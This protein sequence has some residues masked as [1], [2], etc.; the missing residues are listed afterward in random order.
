M[1]NL[2]RNRCNIGSND[3]YIV[4]NVETVADLSHL[5]YFN[6]HNIISNL[7]GRYC[8]NARQLYYCSIQHIN[9]FLSFN[10]QK[11][12]SIY[13][14]QAINSFK[15]QSQ[16]GILLDL[17]HP[18][19]VAVNAF[20]KMSKGKQNQSII[21]FGESGSGKSETAKYVIKY[22]L[23]AVPE[24]KS[25][26]H[27][28]SI[29]LADELI[30][31]SV[32][33]ESSSII[34]TD[35]DDE[36]IYQ[37]AVTETEKYIA[38]NSKDIYVSTT[39]QQ[40][41]MLSTTILE[42]FGNAKTM[43]NN[44]SSRFI[45]YVQL[46]YSIPQNSQENINIVGL[47][48]KTYLFEKLRTTH[49]AQNEQNF[50]IFY[51]LCHAFKSNKNLYLQSSD[52]FSYLNKEITV[53]SITKQHDVKFKELVTALKVFGI[54][55]K[56]QFNLW[57]IISGIINLG[58]IN[59][60]KTGDGLCSIHPDSMEYIEA[61]SS[62]WGISTQQIES[63]LTTQSLYIFRKKIV[64]KFYYDATIPN[65][66][67]IATDIYSKVFSWICKR[68]NSAI[69]FIDYDNNCYYIGILDVMGFQNFFHN[70]LYHLCVNHMNE[71]LQQYINESI[72]QKTQIKFWKSEFEE[73]DK[74][75]FE[76][77]ENEDK[78]IFHLL[79]TRN[80]IHKLNCSLFSTDV[81]MRNTNNSVICRRKEAG[82]G[83][84]MGVKPG[85][86]PMCKTKKING[87]MIN[88]F[89][90]EI[91]YDVGEEFLSKNVEKINNDTLDMMRK[92][93]NGLMQLLVKDTRKRS[94][95]TLMTSIFNSKLKKLM[96]NLQSTDSYFILCM[97]TNHQK[98][99]S[100]W[101]DEIVK[102]Q[103]LGYG[104]LDSMKSLRYK[105][106]FMSKYIRQINGEM[107]I[108]HEVVHL[109]LLYCF[110]I[111]VGNV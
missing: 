17:S 79:Q 90:D 91:T 38:S 100:V 93:T 7:K 70:S 34:S 9:V 97:N 26:L 46:F 43:R 54:G 77:I 86:W 32:S 15:L 63:R 66:D 5:L 48:L 19:A 95:Y 74:K 28:S 53:N 14:T 85:N 105:D 99:H 61:L 12:L 109:I 94:R 58:N 73:Q 76:L 69:S 13:D 84:I 20:I 104:I 27:E 111:C 65:R 35:T 30:D 108:P 81:L 49:Q 106:L 57:M 67:T 92:S 101:N 41:I 98:S 40:Q 29:D 2:T 42:A 64:K 78:G 72:T 6:A 25:T 68:I 87:I 4:E 96:M 71:K 55:N 50:H 3:T 11:P 31:S 102:Q 47:Y 36:K 16:K 62:L 37:T 21:I 88:H 51:T 59:F 33:S 60:H 24:R 80:I 18:Y 8:N 52:K 39:I 103:I 45:K 44:N 22:L 1:S 10:P 82:T 107:N 110:K 83:N 23:S 75:Y 89:N 56:L